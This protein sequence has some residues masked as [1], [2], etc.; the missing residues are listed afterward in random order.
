MTDIKSP[1]IDNIVNS[2]SQ[3][4]LAINNIHERLNAIESVLGMAEEKPREE[5]EALM[6]LKRDVNSRRLHTSKKS[7]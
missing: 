1:T 3:L 7:D 2:I 5:E 6:K 4:G